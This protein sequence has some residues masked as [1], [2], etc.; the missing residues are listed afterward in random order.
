MYVCTWCVH[1]VVCVQCGWCRH[2]MMCVHSV[3]CV[4]SVCGV[5]IVWCVHS[6]ADVCVQRVWCR[7]GVVLHMVCVHDVHVQCVNLHR[8]TLGRAP[9][10]GLA[11]SACVIGLAWQEGRRERSSFPLDTFSVLWIFIIDSC[12]DV[13]ISESCFSFPARPFK[14]KWCNFYSNSSTRD[15]FLR[16]LIWGQCLILQSPLPSVRDVPNKR[17]DCQRH[18]FPKALLVDVI[19]R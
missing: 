2:A 4:C 9:T 11:E 7:H 1:S 8:H 15:L 6:M 16:N 3:V 14:R 5:Y 12:T 13:L 18:L 17:T 19:M 10:A